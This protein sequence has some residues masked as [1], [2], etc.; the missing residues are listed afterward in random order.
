MKYLRLIFLLLF[1]PLFLHAYDQGES[2]NLYD[3]VV[4]EWNQSGTLINQANR[5]SSN[6]HDKRIPLLNEAIAACNRAI[7]HCNAFFRDY[8]KQPSKKRNE[9]WRIAMKNQFRDAK[10]KCSARISSLETAIK[11]ITLVNAAFEKVNLSLQEGQKKADLAETKNRECLRHLNNADTVVTML[12]EVAKLYEEAATYVQEAASHIAT[13]GNASDKKWLKEKEQNYLD[14]A[15]KYRKEAAEWPAAILAQKSILNEKLATL[16]EERKLF[17]EQ[18]LKR[19]AYEVQKQMV[20]ILEQLIKGSSVHDEEILQLK[21]SLALYEA[22]ADRNRLTN[23]T[24]TLTEDE[25]RKREEVRRELFY[26]KQLLVTPELFLPSLFSQTTRPFALSLDGQVSKKDTYFTL[27]TEQF[28]RF[29]IQSDLPATQILVKVGKEGSII[30][31]E[32]ITLPLKN[33]QSW[34]QYVKD[35]GMIFIPETRLKTEF[36]VELRISFVCDPKCTFSM[37]VAQK[38]T[39]PDYQ[40]SIALDAGNALYNTSFLV[41]PPWQL[42]SLRKPALPC[43]NV[44]TNKIAPFVTFTLS[45]HL[46]PTFSSE[47]VH[48]PGL[49]QFVGELKR[50]PLALAGYVQNEIALVD[51]FLIQ[52]NGVFQAPGIHRNA[53]R[54]YL[55]KQGS[56]W[57]QCQ[58]LVYLLRSAGYQALYIKGGLS[59]LPKIFV[60]KMLFTNL[61][62][63]QKEGVLNY[64]F[65]LFFNGKNWVSLFPWMK[66]MQIE[67]GYDLYNF[68]PEEY[69]SADRW[70]LRYLKSDERIIK[71]IAPDGN[72]T[73]G[74][75]FIRFVEEEIRKQGLSLMD[76]GVHR[77]Q[78]KKQFTCWEDFPRPSFSGQLQIID[79]LK[80]S[81]LFAMAQIEIFSQE[82]PQKK[83]SLSVPLAEL[84]CSIISL[85]F[86]ANSKNGHRLFVQA[87]ERPK[88]SYL[89]LDESDHVMNIK[90]TY[91]VPL[92]ATLSQ[93]TQ[94]LS[95]AKGTSAALCFHFGGASPQM[96]SQFY[97]QFAKEKDE[98]KRIHALLAFVGTSY[99]EKCGR[100]ESLIAD[101]HKTRPTTALAFGL[102]KL[103]PDSSKGPIKGEPDLKLPQVD[104]F[105]FHANPPQNPPPSIWN[106]E[107]YTASRQLKALITVDSSSNEHQ[108]LSEIFKD[109]YPIS[110]VKL[111]QLA[112]LQHKKNGLP[113]EGF[114]IFTPSSFEAAENTPEVAQALYFSHLENLN[115]RDVQSASLSS[116]GLLKNLLGQENS[117][118]SWTYAYMTPGPIL[119][120]DGSYKETGA[121]ILNPNTQY[122]L[123]TG[124]NLLFHGGLGSPLPSNYTTSQ[125]ISEWD[126]VLT[127]H[128]YT[129]DVARP[130][131]TFATPLPSPRTT[132][133]IPDVR[134]EHKA[135]T[136]TV[137]DPIDV[138][139]GAFY[140]DEVDLNLPGPFPLEVRRNYNSQNP[141]LGDFGCGWKLGLNPFLI[142]QEGKLYAAEADG[143]IIIYR[144]IPEN[145]R[146]QVSFEDNPDLCNFSQRGMGGLANPFHAYIKDNVLYSTDG[147]TRHFEKG[148]LKK[149][150]DAKGCILTFF[151]N[152]KRLSRIENSNGDF[153]GFHYNHEGK[154]SEAYV[155][156]GRR[157]SYNYD[158]QG[159]LTQVTL[160]NTAK[161]FY[162]YDRFHRIIRET[163]PHGKV[164]ENIYDDKGRVVEQRAPMGLQQELITNATLAYQE[165]LTL[166]TDAAGGQTIYKI[167]QKQIYKITD[168]LGYQTYSSWFIDDKTWFDPLTESVINWN[169]PGAWPRSLK[170]TTDKRGLTTSYLYDKKGNPTE[171]TLEGEDLTGNGERSVTKKLT[172]N[173]RNLCIQEDILDHKTVTTYLDHKP[174]PI[175]IEKY[176]NNTLLSYIERRY[177]SVGQIIGEDQPGASVWWQYDTHGFLSQKNQIT[178]TADANVVSDYSYNH[179]G[180]CIKVTT[181]DSIQQNDY[182]IMGNL[183]TSK[184]YSPNGTLLS[185]TYLGYNLNNQPIWKQ[186]ANAQN[187]LHLDYHASG[188]LQAKRQTLTSNAIAYTL[189]E[190]DSRGNLIQEVDPRGACIYRDY[191]ALNRIQSETREGLSTLFS[192]ESG[193]LVESVTTPSGAKTT[194]LY[195][196]NGL[197]KE[198]IYPDGTKNSIV[199]DF[200]GRPI[201]EIKNNITWEIT[202][203]DLNRKIIH[204]HALTKATETQTF[205]ARGNLISFTDAAGYTLKKTY[206]GLNRIK[207]ETTPNGDTT[208]WEYQGS[209]MYC[210]LPSNELI[211]KRYEAG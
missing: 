196:T 72:D 131:A 172:Y 156:D 127:N 18:G 161:I 50:D 46:N 186:T 211:G 64:P 74:V 54:T 78:I 112:H 98:T 87:A 49:N 25:F 80:S 191:D 184:H 105:W 65:V 199:Y 173:E 119:S 200:F 52:E 34:E 108:I 10:D 134:P 207:T 56:P 117:L 147:S 17:E 99:F 14:T 123:I 193:G 61:P 35:D 189:Y 205:D 210:I 23:S 43:T 154:I 28:Y 39:C 63:E 76:V 209:C 115:L 77:T 164:L 206:D 26:A 91:E 86:S 27:Y 125:G 79:S 188:L 37:I 143:S 135:N 160:P 201:R 170:S 133:W 102:A 59:T 84:N 104:M 192:Y 30:H 150:I 51:P 122:A 90:L 168:P 140:I 31:E 195:T 183:L 6:Q 68:M 171:I 177:N 81:N 60:E 3:K 126:L 47:P 2:K 42:S 36:G 97:E 41:P 141:L 167:F 113:G 146:W 132:Q 138:V 109:P 20:A 94:T 7:G 15:T 176:V 124:N 1:I 111:L 204:I 33:I 137:A 159:D 142:E 24:Q 4:A 180:Q 208:H 194:R 139:S 166:V 101:L 157:V 197:L 11:E 162:E 22:E 66:E 144:Y 185:A 187:T 96:T 174:L 190:Y 118:S 179:Q 12:H 182:D 145:S 149:W 83:L 44:P 106:Q 155:K 29:L 116:W 69:A 181:A 5:L 8:G 38:V 9:Q 40:L 32:I 73:A 13:C 48:F 178:K 151:Y 100:T 95:F 130:T 202:Y 129:L 16:R 158:S 120:L 62:K 53:Y 58:L 152:E 136:H 75:L 93:A 21:A 153:L 163:K 103:S 121:L 107:G 82:N 92:G 67:E 71:H 85:Y 110:T 45:E 114:A 57:E 198:E 169:Q 55:E 70:I 148:L 175:R 19:S 165:G 128:G 88:A 203:D 89:D